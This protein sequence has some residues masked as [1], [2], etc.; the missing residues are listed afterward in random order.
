[1]SS[2]NP[3]IPVNVKRD[4]ATV[5]C[6]HCT[7]PVPRGLLREGE[8]KQF[9]CEG[10]RTVHEVI[11]GCGLEQY[12]RL[13]QHDDAEARPASA[14]GKRYEEFDDP[15]FAGLYVDSRP[16]GV[17]QVE[18]FLDGVHC[19]A[20]VWLVEK[21]PRILKGVIE[22]RLDFGRRT[23][24]LSWDP[25]TVQLSAIA[26]QLA[27]LGYAPH[28]SRGKSERERRRIEDR[29]HLVR[30]AVAGAIAG[31]VMVIA[32]AL[33]GG[34]FH[35]I[36]PQYRSF[37]H[38]ISMGLTLVS[39][40][41]PGRV[42]FRGARAAWRTRTMHMDVPISIGLAAGVT[43]SSISTITGH[44]DGYFDTLTILIFLL[45]VGRWIQA[46]Q[47]QKSRDAV[48]LLFSMTP[49]AARVIREDGTECEVPLEALR[50]GVNVEVRAGESIPVDGVV[51][52]GRSTLDT[53]LLT[54]ESRPVS[55]AENDRVHA[56]TINLAAP[57]RIRI[58]EIGETTR[59]GRLM[60]LV[61][62][63]AARRAPV[64]RLA[65]RIAGVFV[66]VILSLAAITIALW[67]ML[68]PG[69]AVPNAMALLIVTCPCALGLATPLAIVA[70]IG[71]A[72]Q[73]GMLIKGGEVVERLN[74]PGLIM[75]DKTGTITEGR[76][77]LV[78]WRGDR[79]LKPLVALI[80]RASSH[81]IA[82]A[83]ARMSGAQLPPDAPP[84]VVR[85]LCEVAGK[86]IHAVVD[87]RAFHI[88]SVAFMRENMIPIAGW[89]E[90]AVGEMTGRAV[91]P[92]LIA[93]DGQI[94]A[95]AGV[96]DPIKADAREAIEKLRD[97]GWTIGILSGDHPDVVAAVAGEL[98]L[99]P[100]L[101]RGGVIPEEKLARIQ[102][103]TRR[104]DRG[105]VVMVGDGVNDAA[106]LAAASVGI[107][108]KGGAEASFSAADVYLNTPGLLPVVNLITGSKRTFGV[109]RRNIFI[110]LLYNVLGVS[111]AMGGLLNPLV[112]AI[113][114]PIS[115]LSVITISYR[116]RTFEGW[117]SEGSAEG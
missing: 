59:V 53:S 106:A 94:R 99:D 89:V 13:R 104:H 17:Q 25:A 64:V 45:L 102:S 37:F 96:G 7:L 39:V 63:S 58:T 43:Y 80:E 112:A 38:W 9:C 52:D 107:A 108:V 114:M 55:I 113:V 47:Q 85:D 111:L 86:G 11:H 30:I 2:L 97:H 67:L 51:L 92:I 82:R 57:L 48:E 26:R 21:L 77:N 68:E 109:I 41:W 101:C 74:Q 15:A 54:G 56:G 84:P 70:G 62:D 117:S 93:V 87:D 88:G 44:Y 95:L 20:C 42:F 76:M 40:A 12:Y 60:K 31:N 72:A 19:S 98:G 65:D 110:S 35:G 1:M 46:R 66:T 33:Y 50:V 28:P 105:P 22:A 32:F 10:C 14:P 100:E 75:L 90:P 8:G 83:L 78:D 61:E 91:T 34:M 49:S 79:D 3:A 115:S 69:R 103:F 16:P 116:S 29:T 4:A 23:V 6:A 18:L 27:S 81:P 73:R 5:S 24:R 71:R 36:E